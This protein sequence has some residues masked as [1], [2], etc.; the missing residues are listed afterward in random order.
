MSSNA[1]HVESENIS[2]F[3]FAGGE[4]VFCIAFVWDRHAE[5]WD[6]SLLQGRFSG[7]DVQRQSDA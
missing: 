6:P 7:V 3:L 4:E 1:A 2:V 5:P